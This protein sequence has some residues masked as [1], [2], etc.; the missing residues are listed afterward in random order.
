VSINKYAEGPIAGT[1]NENNLTNYGGVLE[2]CL[3]VLVISISISS[4]Y[5]RILIFWKDNLYFLLS[6]GSPF[7]KRE[8]YLF[9]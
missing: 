7:W 6:L 8:E 4:F 5:D 2:F 9:K 1:Y 3:C